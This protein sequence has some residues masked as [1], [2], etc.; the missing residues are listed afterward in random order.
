ME[1]DGEL[2][3]DAALDATIAD[4]KGVTS[5][6]AGKANV[7]VFPDLNSGNIAF[8]L[9]QNL[10][11]QAR[12]AA[13]EMARAPAVQKNAALKRLATLLRESGSA[14]QVENAK[15]LERAA[16][17]G[18]AAPMVSRF[19]TSLE[20]TPDQPAHPQAS[21]IPG[22]GT[23]WRLGWLP[24]GA[25]TTKPGPIHQPSI[26]ARTLQFVLNAS[27]NPATKAP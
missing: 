10:G 7:L 20:L 24:N 8:K 17:A 4:I 16:A 5:S 2:Q 19:T 26:R 15:D 27:F 1:I 9:M 21:G 3:V 23:Y 22:I 6:V 13:F 25:R 18:L 11:A 14:L 12:R